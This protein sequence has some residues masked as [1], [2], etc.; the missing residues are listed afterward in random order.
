MKPPAI[1]YC[2]VSSEKQKREGHGLDSQEHRCRQY[3]ESESLNVL[4]VFKDDITGAEDDRSGMTALLEFL[5]QRGDDEEPIAVIIDDIKRWARDVEVHFY[6][7]KAVYERNGVLRS[8]NFKFGDSP[9]DKFF[10]TMM[11]A[12]AELERT[13]NARQVKQKM[14]ARL[15][16][17]Y[18]C[19]DYP[20][21]YKYAKVPEH[22]KLLVADEPKATTVTEA[23]EGFASGRF[24]DQ[25]DVQRFLESRQ[26]THRAK[27]GIVHLEQVK[28]ILT[29]VLYAGYVE[30]P[31]WGVERRKGHHGG[32][33]GIETF[34][35]IQE[36][37]E[38]KAKVPQR[39][40]LNKDFPLRGFVCCT[41]C[42]H[43][44]TANWSTG[45]GKV[46]HAYYRC[47]GKGCAF[48]GK[49]ILRKTM[50][51]E[52]LTL[53]LQLKPKPG[54]VALTKAV[55]LDYWKGEVVNVEQRRKVKE[56]R[57]EGIEEK[58]KNLYD[59]IEQTKSETLVKG[60]EERI[61]QLTEEKRQ[62]KK[63]V[64]KF[65]TPI[66]FETALDKV[67]E[68]VEDPAKMWQTKDLT[69]Q[70]LTLKLVFSEKLL[71]LRDFGFET[72]SLSLPFAISG[73]AGVSKSKMVE[74]PGIEPGSNV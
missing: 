56:S 51:D 12:S 57:L 70:R 55:I 42:K 58:I 10:E 31:E 38:G 9:E 68:F 36:L 1:I 37:L 72:A 30:Y 28:R 46:K 48:Y 7:R 16:R 45:R 35:R 44:Y 18:W 6:F 39:R 34:E 53:L 11:A 43:P 19:F 62:V 64:R 40:D 47:I 20:P 13:Q 8:P 74:M 41:A 15:E 4:G 60:Y 49:S 50:E 66:N 69:K 3:A 65:K 21:G 73:M 22:G 25:T 23:L 63:V 52:F 27:P 33:I 5:E 71:Y 2:R 26:F 29:Q 59:R 24:P 32:L 54:V 61:E 67:M 14:K 17:G